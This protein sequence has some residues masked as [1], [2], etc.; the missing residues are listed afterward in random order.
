MRMVT[1][2]LTLALVGAALPGSTEVFAQQPNMVHAHIGHVS[3][4]FRDTPEGRGLLTTAQ[5]EAAVV[6]QHAGFM[7]ND[8]SNLDMAKRHAGHVLHAI[9]PTVVTTGPGLGYGLKKAGTSAITHIEMAAGL[10]NASANVKT[11]TNHVA[12]SIRA[13]LERADQV[14]DLA[15]KIQAATTAAEVAP[16]VQQLNTLAQQIVTGVDANGD[17]RITWEAAEGGLDQ[18]AQHMTL[19][20]RAEGLLADS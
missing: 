18:A 12:T 9:D 11:H 1:G 8:P 16:L 13:S 7:A 4:A 14:A 17:G 10:D 2:A 3:D 5:A 15:R 19:M 20:K 6:A